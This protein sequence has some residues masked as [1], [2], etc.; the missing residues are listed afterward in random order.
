MCWREEVR[1]LLN[2]AA[3]QSLLLSEAVRSR[4]FVAVGLATQSHRS[5][6]RSG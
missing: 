2:L 3:G 4:L 1:V 5:A 6:E